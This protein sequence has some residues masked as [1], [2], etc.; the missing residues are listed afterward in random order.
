MPNSA[1]TDPPAAPPRT[2][3]PTAH[4]RHT[5]LLLALVCVLPVLASYAAFYVWQPAGRMNYG[6]LIPPTPIPAT[7]LQALG[8]LPPWSGARFQGCWSLVYAGSATCDTACRNALHT[9]RQVRLAQGKE[10]TRVERVWLVTDQ[11]PLAE[12]AHQDAEGLAIARIA[13]PAWFATLPGAESGA[14]IYLI[15]PLGN[16]MMRFPPAA[17]PQRMVK[18]LQRLLKYSALG[19]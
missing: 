10:M 5:L 15:D 3:P 1:L 18:D 17:D 2:V 12:I 8:G 7:G 11:A 14:H 4:A 19:R 16:A 9:L 13:D 6:E